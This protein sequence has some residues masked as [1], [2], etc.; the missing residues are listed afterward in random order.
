MLIHF[1]FIDYFINVC[2]V[3]V[4]CNSIPACILCLSVYTC[5]P[6]WYSQV[7]WKPV[8]CSLSTTDG[9]D[10]GGKRKREK[11]TNR[12]I[13]RQSVLLKRLPGSSLA[14]VQVPGHSLITCSVFTSLIH[15]SIFIVGL[16]VSAITQTHWTDWAL[17]ANTWCLFM[18]WKGSWKINAMS[19][20]N[21]LWVEMII[22]CL[23]FPSAFLFERSEIKRWPFNIKLFLVA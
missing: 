4:W 6:T 18:Y 17:I 2:C 7:C 13:W 19:S 15:T 22:K 3:H 23:L 16:C 12:R 8:V 20:R 5:F 11:S 21:S 9:R 10:E 14:Y 1:L